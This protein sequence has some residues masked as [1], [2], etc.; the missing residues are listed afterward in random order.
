MGPSGRFRDSRDE[1]NIR[2]DDYKEGRRNVLGRKT[3]S[4][5]ID[6]D[7]CRP[8]NNTHRRRHYESSH[9]DMR[10]TKHED[11]QH[12]FSDYNRRTN[13][14]DGFRTLPREKH[15]ARAEDEY[16]SGSESSSSINDR[17][18]SDSE[19]KK[20]VEGRHD[21]NH[22][23]EDEPTFTKS[24]NGRLQQPKPYPQYH[25]GNTS[26]GST[27][28]DFER[29][30]TRNHHSSK[31]VGTY[32][33]Y[34]GQF[35]GSQEYW[36]DIPPTRKGAHHDHPGQ[37]GH[38]QR[39]HRQPPKNKSHD[40][41]DDQCDHN[42]KGEHGRRKLGDKSSSCLEPDV[43]DDPPSNHYKTLAI[44]SDASPDE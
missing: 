22:E 15:R 18:S 41:G 33:Q 30:S 37:G 12:I 40:V 7:E 34:R 38:N 21:L 6:E 2:Y 9:H 1:F 17:D 5:F 19:D 36:K 25:S 10:D 35:R 42:S 28:T 3:A 16:E 23:G 13:A 8:Q 29:V 11:E 43:S 14:R 39:P 24:K 4:W 44:S 32:S 20:T 26:L 31:N 27:H